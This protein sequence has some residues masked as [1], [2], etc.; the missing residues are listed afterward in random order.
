MGV[1][2]GE[3]GAKAAPCI[4]KICAEK[5]VFIISSGIKQILPLLS[6]LEK[7]IPT[8]MIGSDHK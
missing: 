6:P 7:I 5:I 2:E 3:G 4:L 8:P 1:E